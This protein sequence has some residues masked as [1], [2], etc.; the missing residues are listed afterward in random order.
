MDSSMLSVTCTVGG[1]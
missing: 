1:V